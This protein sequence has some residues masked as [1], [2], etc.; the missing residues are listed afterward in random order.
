MKRVI[1]DTDP[2]IDDAAAIFLALASPELNVEALTTG[3]GNAE[4]EQCTRNALKILEVADRA[5]IPVYTGS[6]KPIVR[7][8][9]Y[10]KHVHGDNGL[11]GIAYAPAQGRP[12][13]SG[14]AEAIV[15]RVMASPG[16]L[17]LIAL[18]PL[19]NVALAMALEPRI[20]DKLQSLILMGGAVLTWGN[21]SPAATANLVNDPEA[22]RIVY[23]SG[24]PLVQVGLDVCRPTL[25][26]PGHMALIQQADNEI[27]QFLSRIAP[28]HEAAERELGIQTAV[29]GLGFHFNDVPAIAYAIRPDLFTTRQLPVDIEIHGELSTG[30]TVADFEGRWGKPA[31]ATV[32]LDVDAQEVADLFARRLAN[33]PLPARS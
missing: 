5:D 3:F 24:A 13:A 4:V 16:E 7:A 11:G 23:N 10:A 18:G 19:T 17:T 9:R 25:I 31:N 26:T 6:S 14:A 15:A 33:G 28:F 22:A 8:P 12:A 20:A 2:G 21:V 27:C 30:Q 29:D 1:I 32:C